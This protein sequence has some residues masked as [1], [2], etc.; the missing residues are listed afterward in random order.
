MTIYDRIN[1]LLKNQHKTRKQLCEDTGISYHTLTSLFQRQ[2][3]NINLETITKIADYLGISSEYL[4]SGKTLGSYIV[5]ESAQVPLDYDLAEI[6]R[7]L[8][9]VIK[10]LSVKGKALLLSRAYELE[11]KEHKS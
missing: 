4:I 7:E 11:E 3:K 10:K 5:K 1:L 2:S 6:D 9:K 8:F